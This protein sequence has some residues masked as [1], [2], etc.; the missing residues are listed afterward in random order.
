MSGYILKDEHWKMIEPLLDEARDA[1]GRKPA[2]SNRTAFEGVLYIMKEGCRWRS[3]PAKYGPWMAV[4]MRYTR[5]V[6]RGVFWNVLMKLQKL[7]VLE[8]KLVFMDSTLIRAHRSAAGA[9]KKGATKRS[10]AP[11]ADSEAKS[12]S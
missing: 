11:A 2:I 1:R 7:N 5:W 6:K 4:M 9:R 8:V 12:M 3:L 10:D